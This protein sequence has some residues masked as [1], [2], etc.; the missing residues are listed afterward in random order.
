MEKL[1]ERIRLYKKY[2]QYDE[3]GGAEVAWKKIGDFWAE[4]STSSMH[5]THKSHA[6]EPTFTANSLLLK[7]HRST[8]IQSDM[9]VEWQQ[10]IYQVLRYPVPIPGLQMHQTL[11]ALVGED[12]ASSRDI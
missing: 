10:Q 8:P 5:Y 3:L 11:I 4:L 2:L 12:N 7:A 6:V 9:R 1:K